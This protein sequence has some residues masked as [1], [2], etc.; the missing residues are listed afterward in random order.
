MIASH[1]LSRE[2]ESGLIGLATGVLVYLFFDLMHEAVELTGARD[3]APGRS[4]C[5]PFCSRYLSPTT[6]R[7]PRAPANHSIWKMNMADC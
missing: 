2:W 7:T 1:T 5:V 6:P 4:F 3:L